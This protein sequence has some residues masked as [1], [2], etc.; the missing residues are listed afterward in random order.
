MEQCADL[1]WLTDLLDRR[2]IAAVEDRSSYVSLNIYG[3]STMKSNAK[4]MEAKEVLFFSPEC[5]AATSLHFIL[6]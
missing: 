4:E 2:R 3:K 5:G 6:T 1:Y